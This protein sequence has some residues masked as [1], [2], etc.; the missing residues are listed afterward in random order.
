M[1]CSS[2]L[3]SFDYLLIG[4]TLF[5]IGRFLAAFTQWFLKPRWILLVSYIGMIVFA[6]LC[7]DAH[8]TGGVAM[9]LML[10][11]FESGAFSII[12]AISLRGLGPYTKTGASIMT[13]AV[14]GGSIF[15][16]PQQAVANSRGT[17]YSFCVVVALFAAGAIFPLYL[18]LV[19]AAR[20]QVDPVPNEYLRRH[21]PRKRRRHEVDTLQREKENPSLGGV[22]SRPRSLVDESFSTVRLPEGVHVQD[23]AM[24]ESSSPSTQPRGGGLMHDL[25]P[26]PD[27]ETTAASRE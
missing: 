21:Y 16:F 19:P 3:S 2:Q 15:P 4:R 9:G 17:P 1:P 20:K 23:N 24:S 13:A 25:A 12:F 11:L 14:S 27:D 26:W 8:G 18:N 6:V 7:M 22:L 5:A 10:F